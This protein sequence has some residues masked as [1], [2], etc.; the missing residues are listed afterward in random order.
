ME[1][2]WDNAG[3]GLVVGFS[4]SPNVSRN[5]L[6]LYSL[7]FFVRILSKQN[8]VPQGGEA[9][10][11]A[12]NDSGESVIVCAIIERRF[13]AGGIKAHE[14]YGTWPQELTSQGF[15]LQTQTLSYKHGPTGTVFSAVADIYCK[16]MGCISSSRRGL[17]MPFF[18][19]STLDP[20]R[21]LQE[22]APTMKSSFGTAIS[23]SS[24]CA[25]LLVAAAAVMATHC[26]N[27]IFLGIASFA[28]AAVVL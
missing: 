25:E 9:T 14:R 21:C 26:W 17:S 2:F 19:Y 16:A 23:I 20:A 15:A 5:V 28:L 27:C 11:T 7:F 6:Y 24:E 10:V 8:L 13:V 12:T 22:A 18:S 4:L 3:S 1:A